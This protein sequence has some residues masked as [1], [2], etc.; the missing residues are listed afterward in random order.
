MQKSILSSIFQTTFQ[1]PFLFGDEKGQFEKTGPSKTFG[2]HLVR[3]SS[4]G[5]LCYGAF[6]SLS[7]WRMESTFAPSCFLQYILQVWSSK[8]PSLQ[9][10]DLGRSSH[11]TEASN[12]VLKNARNLPQ[13]PQRQNWNRTFRD[14]I[15]PQLP[16]PEPTCLS[17]PPALSDPEDVQK[18]ALGGTE[19]MVG[20]VGANDQRDS[21]NIQDPVAEG[22]PGA[23]RIGVLME[24]SLLLLVQHNP[25]Q[26]HLIRKQSPGGLWA[27]ASV[28]RAACPWGSFLPIDSWSPRCTPC[29][30]SISPSHFAPATPTLWWCGGELFPLAFLAFWLGRGGGALRPSSGGLPAQVSPAPVCLTP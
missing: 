7:C 19:R 1:E 18:G 4:T 30:L 10:P 17:Q 16:P 28:P 13:E 15:P 27:L 2:K 12:E 8:E 22:S 21:A 3:R 24:R 20:M 11:L 25:M 9:T 23:K 29:P 26:T 6:Q 14:L 5:F